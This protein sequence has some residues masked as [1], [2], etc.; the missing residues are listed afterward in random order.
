MT[1]CHLLAKAG[2]YSSLCQA[3]KNPNLPLAWFGSLFSSSFHSTAAKNEARVP[4]PQAR[5]ERPRL[6]NPQEMDRVGNPLFRLR[7]DT[8]VNRAS[9]EFLGPIKKWD[10]R[11]R[12][13]YPPVEE[14]KK[15]YADREEECPR[16]QPRFVVHSRQ[17]I[18]GKHRSL[19]YAAFMVMGLNV[20]DAIDQLDL[21]PFKQAEELKE[22]IQEAVDM[23]VNEHGIE[24][25]S[26]MY[27]GHSR[28][29]RGQYVIGARKRAFGNFQKIKYEYS[30][31]VVCLIEGK[32]PEDFF[33][34]DHYCPEY[35]IET[36]LKQLR[37][38]KI[39]WDLQ[40]DRPTW[41]T[42]RC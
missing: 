25:R 28:V 19:N 36:R 33:P 20:D 38:R 24:F 31:Y 23:A 17:Q 10:L 13:V 15:F 37:Q 3:I 30:N 7:A 41:G 2:P 1:H 27:V 9:D 11:N 14:V 4:N 16:I 6:V 12:V 5:L 40:L 18:R 22:T 21:H 42:K 8:A 26:N 29:S 39:H 34:H 32:A 35:M